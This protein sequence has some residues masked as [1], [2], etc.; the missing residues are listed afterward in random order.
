MYTYAHPLLLTSIKTKE[1]G[2]IRELQYADDSTESMQ[3]DLNTALYQSFGLQVIIK[4]TE[5]MF[6]LMN[7]TS[8]TPLLPRKWHPHQ[9]S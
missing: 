2:Q 6:Q 1:T 9:I 3:Y 8:P 5:I 4:K 7:Q